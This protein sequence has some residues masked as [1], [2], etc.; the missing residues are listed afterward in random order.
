ME[1]LI[2]NEEYLAVFFAG[3]CSP[4]DK[5]YEMLENLENIDTNLQ[6]YGIMMVMTE[7]K[8][9]ARQNE[10][11]FFPSLGLFRCVAKIFSCKYFF[12]RKTLLDYQIHKK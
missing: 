1:R 10:N 9:V 4:G 8:E 12:L 2:E 3:K 5:C 11:F 7:D 6:D